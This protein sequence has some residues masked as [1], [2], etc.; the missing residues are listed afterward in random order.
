MGKNTQIKQLKEMAKR[1]RLEAIEMAHSTGN[2]GSHLGGGLSC[3]EILA[4][5][6]GKVLNYDVKNPE[7]ED[8]DIFLPSKNHCV[9]AHFPALVEAGYL[10]REEIR[11]FTKDGSRLVG[12]PRNVELGLEY[13]GGSLGMAISVGIGLALSARERNS[14]RELYILMG[15]GELNEGC[16]WEA[17]MSAGHYKLGNLTAI[18]DRNHLSYDGDTEDVMGIEDL[19]AKMR[20]FNWNVISCDGHEVESL[21]NAFEERRQDMPN[22]IIA[23]TVKGKGVS[24]IENRREWHHKALTQEQYEQAKKEIEGE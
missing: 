10:S 24:F 12:Y 8:R 13:S 18:I 16:I 4:V 5:L 1:M 3:I 11:E 20:A 15:D 14:S 7:W 23:E 2:A 17:F 21:V 22:I 6:Y 9:L 19:A